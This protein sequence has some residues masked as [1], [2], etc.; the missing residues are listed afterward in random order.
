[1]RVLVISILLT[2]FP[3]TDQFVI[4]LRKAQTA[5]KSSTTDNSIQNEKMTPEAI[6]FENRLA[7]KKGALFIA[8]TAPS[9]RVALPEEFGMEPGRF[10]D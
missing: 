1:M 9:V 8:Q 10:I 7:N 4:P 5:I 6:E 2:L 3:Q